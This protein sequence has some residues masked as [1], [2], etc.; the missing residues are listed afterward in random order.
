VPEAQIRIDFLSTLALCQHDLILNLFRETTADL[1]NTQF[2]KL[3]KRQLLKFIGKAMDALRSLSAALAAKAT[4]GDIAFVSMQYTDEQRA[5][6]HDYIAPLLVS[7]KL[8]PMLIEQEQG[9][10]NTLS[11]ADE[12][13][14]R[15]D[16]C[17][18]FIADLTG[19]RPDVFIEVGAALILKKNV[20]LIAQTDAVPVNNVPFMLRNV[21]IEFYTSPAELERKLGAALTALL[22]R[23]SSPHA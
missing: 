5:V 11:I 19:L 15:I 16:R 22:D 12:I 2:N 3:S 7:K 1:R 8:E 23:R 4:T 14:R 17:S 20:I 9:F 13:L 18:F 10:P 21:K 6:Y